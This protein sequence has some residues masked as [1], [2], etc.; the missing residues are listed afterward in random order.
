MKH[1]IIGAGPVGR[2]TAN[3]LLNLGDDLTV[4]TRSGTSLPGTETIALDAKDIVSLTSAATGQDTI[5]VA[6]NPPY[7]A[8]KEEWPPLIDA[9]IAAAKSSGAKVVLMGNLY[10]L[11]PSTGPMTEHSPL[12]PRETKGEVR[13]VIWEMLLAEHE[14]GTI[15]AAEVRASDYFGPG[16]G[17]T[18][19]LGD[20]FFKPLLVSKTAYG[21]GRQD[22]PHAWAY[23][24]DIAATIAAVA[25]REDTWGKAWLVPHATQEDRVALAR[26]VTALAGT[27]GTARSI[28]QWALSAMSWFS[29]MTREI[30]RSSYQFRTPFLV[31]SSHSEKVLGTG[32]TPLNHALETTI[33]AYR[34]T[35]QDAVSPR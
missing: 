19:H 12:V 2:N 20:M 29:P 32:A 18:A 21:V 30:V 3:A 28:P 15:R 10:A 31:D 35:P 8:W 1:L 27:H 34:N 22:L 7:P 13:K 9:V 33:A 14:R 25:R 23:L 6:T 4:A 11:D 5:I 24:P 16:A 17:A 26:K